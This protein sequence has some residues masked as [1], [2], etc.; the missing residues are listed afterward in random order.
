LNFFE[1]ETQPSI[2]RHDWSWLLEIT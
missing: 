2:G 1:K